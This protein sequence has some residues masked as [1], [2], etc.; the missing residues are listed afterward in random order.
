MSGMADDRQGSARY[1]DAIRNHWL[2]VALVVLAAVGAAVAYSLLAE[3]RY[4]ASAD[5]LVT[6]IEAGDP[7]FIGINVLRE[8]S[9]SRSVLTAARLAD[10]P[11]VADAVAE[12]LPFAATP[13]GLLEDVEIKPQEQS[14]ILTIAATSSSPERAAAIANGFADALVESRT[15]EFQ[16]ELRSVVERLR[17]QLAA[18]PADERE[19]PEAVAISQRLGDLGALTGAEDPTLHVSSPAVPPAEA[20]WPRPVL[21]VAVALAAAL[22][23]GVGIAVA[24]ELVNPRVKDEEALLLEH[25]L[26]ILAQVPRMRESVVKEYLTGRGPL[27]ADVREAYRTL[28]AS[29]ATAGPE[30]RFPSTI[31]IS[32]AVPG[33]GK[34]MTAMNLGTTLAMAGMRV[35]LVDGDLRRPMLGT[36]LGVPARREAFAEVLLGTASAMEALKP[37]SGFGDRLRLLPANPEQGHLV[38]LLQP[39][40][41]AEVLTE[42]RLDADVILVDSPPL[43]E[44]A[45]ALIL[46]DNADVVVVAVRLGRTR[47]DALA[48]L[49][50][51]L[52]QAGITPAG[53][54][55]TTR[56]RSRRHGYY[57]AAAS[58]AEPRGEREPLLAPAAAEDRPARTRAS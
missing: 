42:L 51:M 45:D 19:S 15:R 2:V 26:P 53:F 17:A 55:V 44:V 11:Q 22:L 40:R 56:R 1:L 32:S 47:R 36:L 28:R 27:P 6:P 4:E 57:A 30:G 38:D 3:K 41:V 12:E 34:T 9:Q 5:V 49:R 54:V 13:K 20:A 35:V 7:T 18:I 16:D 39:D 29:L 24:L 43:T 37:V 8:G 23:L 21:S 14:N 46:A 33:E 48:R 52:S 25:R 58:G 10:T 31:L 50:R